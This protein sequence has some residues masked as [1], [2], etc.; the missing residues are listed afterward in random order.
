MNFFF[1]EHE[2]EELGDSLGIDYVWG[3]NDKEEKDPQKV[4][5]LA[6]IRPTIQ[7]LSRLESEN[8]F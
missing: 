6:N 7:N 8:N 4:K 2:K 1:D 5:G 3:W